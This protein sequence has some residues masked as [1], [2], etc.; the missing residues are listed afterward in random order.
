MTVLPDGFS[1]VT[2]RNRTAVDKLSGGTVVDKRVPLTV[3]A[4]QREFSLPDIMGKSH[5][6]DDFAAF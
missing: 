4:N 2:R 1:I 5:A 6:V 3:N